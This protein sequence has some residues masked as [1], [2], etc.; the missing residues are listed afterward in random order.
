MFSKRA[1]VLV[2]SALVVGASLAG[3]SKASSGPTTT[4]PKATTTS[5]PTSTTAAATTTTVP[6]GPTT[7]TLA[8]H[9]GLCPPVVLTVKVDKASSGAAGTVDYGIDVANSGPEPCTLDGYPTVTLVPV[10]GKVTPVISHAGQGSVFSLL[11]QN[12]SLAASSAPTAGFV[13]QYNDEQSD[14]QTSCP[15]IKQIRVTMPGLGGTFTVNK[16]FYPCGAPNISVSAFVT[17]SQYR[18]AFA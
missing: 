6:S 1:A 15:Q 2:L 14:G 17:E 16:S 13:L 10:S 18:A 9:Y 4:K 3:C 5:S 8:P 11:P 7:T 12:V